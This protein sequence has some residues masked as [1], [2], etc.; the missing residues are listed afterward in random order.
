MAER[1]TP[2]MLADIHA[3]QALALKIHNEVVV[4]ANPSLEVRIFAIAVLA[5]EFAVTNSETIEEAAEIVDTIFQNARSALQSGFEA[6]SRL[7]SE[8]H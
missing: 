6:K 8:Q 1:Y 7:G 5:A 4:P 2:A 3:G